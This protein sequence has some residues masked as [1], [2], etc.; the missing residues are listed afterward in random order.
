MRVGVIVACGL[1]ASCGDTPAAKLR[2]RPDGIPPSLLAGVRPIGRGPRFQPPIEGSIPGACTSRLGIREQAHVELFGA[3]RVVLLAAGIGARAP[4]RLVD[5]RLR[6]AACFGELV[7]LDPTGTVYFRP[8]TH[9]TVGELFSAWGQPLTPKRIASFTGGRVRVYV[10]GRT[11][12]GSPRSV[13]LQSGA[14]IVLEV[15]PYVPPHTRFTFP[16]LPSGR[17]R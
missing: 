6:R 17:L 3:N 10:D 16:P 2:R 5:G 7:T 15:G 8:D 9:P 1:I 12:R 11:R 13:P 14:E 4:R